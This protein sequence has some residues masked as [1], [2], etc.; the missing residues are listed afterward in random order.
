MI[1]LQNIINIVSKQSKDCILNKAC[2]NLN[3]LLFLYIIVYIS[4]VY[5]TFYFNDIQTQFDGMFNVQ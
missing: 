2:F 1:S 3:V 5:K 4:Y